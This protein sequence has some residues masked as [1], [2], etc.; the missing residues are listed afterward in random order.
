V[1]VSNTGQEVVAGVSRGVQIHDDDVEGTGG[2]EAGGSSWVVAYDRS[3]P[4]RP[5]GLDK[6][7]NVAR[8][9]VRDEHPVRSIG[10]AA[11]E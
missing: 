10:A 8:L 4:R 2:D 3:H 1:P 7:V 9:S 11:Q 6:M 5:E